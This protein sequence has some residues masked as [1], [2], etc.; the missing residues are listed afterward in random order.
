M[1][2]LAIDIGTGTQDILLFDSSL[3]P[4]NCSKLVLPSPT[5]IYA[6]QIRQAT[7]ERRAVVLS[8]VLMGGG[9]VSWALGDH[10]QAGLPVYATPDAART[11]DDDLARVQAMGVR[12]LADPQEISN[13][14][15]LHLE[16]R[17]LHLAA[18]ATAL[19]AFGL[20]P[21]WDGLAVAVLDHGAA[22]AGSSDRLFRFEHIRRVVQGSSNLAKVSEP[23]PG[24][25]H[26]PLDLL[27]FA[28]LR[29]ELPNYLTRMCAV[30]ACAPDVPLVLMDTGA[31]A[32]LGAMEDP[33]VQRHNDLLLVNCGNMHTLAI[34]LLDG[35]IAGLLEHHTGF[36]TTEKLDDLL[37]RLAAG[38]LTNDEVFQAG[39]HG[40]YLGSTVSPAS[41][42]ARHALPYPAPAQVQERMPGPYLAVTGPRRGLLRGSRLSP[43][44]AV[45]H[46]D[47]MLAGCYGLVRACAAKLPAWR[48][49]IERALAAPL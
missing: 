46:G 12:L 17:D 6:R 34:R 49:E 7:T 41:T 32:A 9:P 30:A 25:G 33:A 4:E 36:L 10:L 16:L 48:E 22:P 1:R 14:A 2:I 11:L 27:A 18:I 42:G 5:Q 3:E 13:D 20:E 35:R 43:Y 26:W 31:A 37:E 15:A 8:G 19:A 28:Y 40:V 39:G 38:T 23:S 29:D 45:P 21:H 44:F 47:M 24:L